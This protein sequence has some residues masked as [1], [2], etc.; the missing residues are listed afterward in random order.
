M[1]RGSKKQKKKWIDNEKMRGGVDV[2]YEWSIV[3]VGGDIFNH[4]E[5]FESI[6]HFTKHCVMI[7]QMFCWSECNETKIH[8]KIISNC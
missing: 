7:I 6:N 5:N 8:H 2:K 4:F 3:V 1:K